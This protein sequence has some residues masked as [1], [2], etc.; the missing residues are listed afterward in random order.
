MDPT[1]AMPSDTDV[2]LWR[3][4]RNLALSP[5]ERLDQLRQAVR[6]VAKYRGLA[7]SVAIRR[8]AAEAP[9]H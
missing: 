5:D 2:E 7:R 8:P 1:P 6:W 4:R 3:L 9:G